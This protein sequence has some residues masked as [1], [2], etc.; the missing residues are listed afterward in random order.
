MQRAIRQTV[1]LA[2][3]LA[4]VFGGRSLAAQDGGPPVPEVLPF[5]VAIGGHD[6][7]KSERV[8][9]AAVIDQPVPADAAIEVR[10]VD[11]TII[12]NAVPSDES[13]EPLDPAAAP[14]VII[15][16]DA[17][18]GTLADTMD[19]SRLESGTTLL[20]IIGGGKTARVLVTIE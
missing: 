6:A 1:G 13:A 10:G 20:N 3:T 12:I 15:L 16:Q 14:K 19:G 9:V 18:K 2:L 8:A 4:L 5:A 17:G 7:A 11:G